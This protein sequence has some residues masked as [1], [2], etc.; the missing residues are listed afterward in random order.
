MST[1]GVHGGCWSG[2]FDLSMHAGR[3]RV[4]GPAGAESTE[5]ERARGRT[6]QAGPEFNAQMFSEQ[7]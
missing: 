3:E 1:V 4:H 7:D 5:P 2:A 6:S